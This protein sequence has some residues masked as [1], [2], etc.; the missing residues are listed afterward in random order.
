MDYAYTLLLSSYIGD[1]TEWCKECQSKSKLFQ[2]S[3]DLNKSLNASVVVGYPNGAGLNKFNLQRSYDQY[4]GQEIDS[5][6]VPQLSYKTASHPFMLST[7]IMAGAIENKCNQ[8]GS[9]KNKV[10]VKNKLDLCRGDN[11]TICINEAALSNVS[12][13]QKCTP[14][15]PS[16]SVVLTRDSIYYPSALYQNGSINGPQDLA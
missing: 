8:S 13:S 7:G 3:L 9:K 1:S 2:V 16:L 12:E 5:Y 11:V 14:G 4:R 10:V 15:G 6:D